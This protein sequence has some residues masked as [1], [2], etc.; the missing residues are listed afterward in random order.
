MYFPASSGLTRKMISVPSIRIRTLNFRS[1]QEKRGQGSWGDPGGN[2]HTIGGPSTIWEQE[3]DTPAANSLLEVDVLLLPVPQ[4]GEV[5]G[6]RLGLAGEERILGDVDRDVLRRGNDEGRSWSWGGGGEEKNVTPT[7]TGI[8][9]KIAQAQLHR[10]IVGWQLLEGSGVELAPIPQDH[11]VQGLTSR[12]T[13]ALLFPTLSPNLW[14]FGEGPVAHS[15]AAPRAHELTPPFIPSTSPGSHHPRGKM[16]GEN[17]KLPGAGSERPQLAD[18]VKAEQMTPH[19]P[20]SAS[21]C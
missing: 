7:S 20:L 10:S 19:A 15:S 14:S 17:S 2:A 3:E 11:R 18:T 13:A 21:S 8:P 16:Q 1:L 5:P 6:V 4:V 12:G 9:T